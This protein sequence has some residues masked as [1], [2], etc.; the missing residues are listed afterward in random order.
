[1]YSLAGVK[2]GEGRGEREREGVRTAAEHLEAGE[3]GSE[4]GI[5]TGCDEKREKDGEFR[6]LL[7]DW[8]KVLRPDSGIL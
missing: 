4:V 1:M 8:A 2:R 6:D 3:D 5:M 7:L